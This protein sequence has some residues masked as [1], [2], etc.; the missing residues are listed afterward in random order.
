MQFF[1][2]GVR[3]GLNCSPE[4]FIWQ[5]WMVS[6]SWH[7]AAF[8]SSSSA[9]EIHWTH[10]QGQD[11]KTKTQR[12]ITSGVQCIH[13]SSHFILATLRY[14]QPCFPEVPTCS[15]V[16]FCSGPTSPMLRFCPS[17]ML[18]F[19]FP[20]APVPRGIAGHWGR[21]AEGMLHQ[22]S[23]LHAQITCWSHF[24]RRPGKQENTPP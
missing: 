17:P 8:W 18:T 5:M 14:N 9:P 23:S 16:S 6:V 11:T 20:W 21:G 12:G 4:E 7:S 2:F 3:A 22:D 13:T 19:C 24:S 10:G 15:V 1:I